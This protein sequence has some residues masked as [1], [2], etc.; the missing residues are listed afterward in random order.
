MSNSNEHQ[1]KEVPPTSMYDTLYECTKCGKQ[2]FESLDDPDSYLP[3]AGTEKAMCSGV[4]TKTPNFIFASGHPN[5]IKNGTEEKR[6]LVV[7]PE[8]GI[9]KLHQDNL[10]KY[11]AETFCSILPKTE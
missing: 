3:K 11:L 7:Y 4:S 10:E 1:W 8:D 6:F 9:K 2:H 5:P